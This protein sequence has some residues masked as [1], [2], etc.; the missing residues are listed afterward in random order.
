MRKIVGFTL[1]M[2]GLAACA[3][4][5]PNDGDQ[6][7]DRITPDPAALERQAQ[8]DRL[9]KAETQPETVLPPSGDVAT[10]TP[11]GTA[12]VERTAI[13][14]EGD[15]SLS[16]AQ[17]FE[18]VTARE[19]I[20]SD[21]QRLKDLKENYEIVQP[22]QLPKRSGGGINLAKYALSQTN[23]V[24]NKIYK[25]ISLGGGKAARK[26]ATYISADEAQI[27]FLKGGGPKTDRRGLD[28]D[29]DGYACRWTPK[30]FQSMI[31]Q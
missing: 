2:F 26:C 18:S 7:F 13:S 27:A 16:N 22:G 30:S 21:A 17:D 20:K 3:T 19:T 9:A 25:R 14:T 4:P 8:Q 11:E 29:G 1:L 6:Y 12:D 5:P 24:G 31:G 10:T 28:P 15:G 23:P